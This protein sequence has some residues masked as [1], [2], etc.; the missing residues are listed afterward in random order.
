MTEREMTVREI[1]EELRKTEREI[2]GALE[3]FKEKTGRF[4]S[5]RDKVGVGGDTLVA[6]LLKVEL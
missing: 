3:R 1:Q 5:Y 6:V 4:A 2:S